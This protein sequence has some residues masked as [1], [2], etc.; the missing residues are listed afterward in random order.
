[1][2]KRRFHARPQNGNSDWFPSVSHKWVDKCSKGRHKSRFT[3]ADVKARYSAEEE[4]GLD[5]FV[6]TPTPES[7]NLLEVYALQNC[8]YTRSLDIVAAFLI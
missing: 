7:H 8:F 1:M 3:C 5:V 4:D 2:G 6:P